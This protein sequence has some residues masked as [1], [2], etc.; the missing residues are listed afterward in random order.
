MESTASDPARN[1]KDA[2]LS[3]LYNAE[4]P[5]CA[6]EIDHYAR[7]ANRHAL[8]IRFDPFHTTDLQ[9]Y[10]ITADLA[11]RRL[12]VLHQGRV[13]SG[14]PA[15]L[16]LWRAMPGYHWL[17]RFVGMPGVR[18]AAAGLYDH[19]LAPLLYRLHLRR[20]ARAR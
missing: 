20:Q 5:I 12:H 8:P 6:R 10:G 4:C 1:A 16:L 18:H 3:V 9:A 19:I 7:H 15:F 2:G 11:A 17:A 13:V 14:V